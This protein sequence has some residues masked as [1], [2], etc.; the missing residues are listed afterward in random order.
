MTDDTSV[1]PL[2]FIDVAD[3]SL[4]EDVF[5]MLGAMAV[6][7]RGEK[8]DRRVNSPPPILPLPRH[9]KRMARVGDDGGAR[10]DSCRHHDEHVCVA[11]QSPPLPPVS[12]P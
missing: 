6:A 3:V 10:A 2:P 5:H 8:G 7:G 1:A 4:H 11:S 9:V 12:R